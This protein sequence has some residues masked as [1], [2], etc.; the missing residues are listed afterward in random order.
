MKKN[1]ALAYIMLSCIVVFA[2][3]D[4]TQF[5]NAIQ[6]GGTIA[7]TFRPQPWIKGVGNELVSAVIT[8]IG[9]LIFGIVKRHKEKKKLR[10]EGKLND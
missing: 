3:P 5:Y 7:N 10:K 9:M 6:I 2:Q 4:S 1:I 8:S